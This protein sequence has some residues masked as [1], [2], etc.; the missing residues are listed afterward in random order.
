MFIY[1]G[2]MPAWSESSMYALKYAQSQE[3]LASLELLSLWTKFPVP[4]SGVFSHA[5]SVVADNRP[6]KNFRHNI[7]DTGG[8]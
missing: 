8:I 2:P 7:P 6:E 3:F 5:P 1:R 4:H